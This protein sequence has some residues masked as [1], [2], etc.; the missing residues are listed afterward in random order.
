[1][2][3]KK[4]ADISAFE[5]LGGS[6]GVS[7]VSVF[8]FQVSVDIDDWE[9]WREFIEYAAPGD[10]QARRFDI[11]DELPIEAQEEFFSF[12]ED[13]YD[14]NEGVEWY[15]PLN[16]YMEAIENTIGSLEEEYNGEEEEEEEE[17]ED[18]EE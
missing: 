3:M 2:A 10:W 15:E 11:I 4:L 1:M 7:D 8:N 17:D 14:G 12:L 5:R 16:Q 13:L 9:L 18:W 6:G